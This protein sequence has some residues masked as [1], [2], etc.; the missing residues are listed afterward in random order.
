MVLCLS[1]IFENSMIFWLY[2]RLSTRC[3][4]KPANSLLYS[5]AGADFIKG[6]LLVPSH[7]VE[8]VNN[9]ARFTPFINCFS[10]YLSLFHITALAADRFWAV[11][12]PL[13][14]LVHHD[15]RAPSVELLSIWIIPLVL[16][17]I[18]LFGSSSP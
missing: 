1:I 8:R 17:I 5:Q 9:T 13:R 18:P 2:G 12:R 7:I 4:E 15:R 3:R 11:L 16:A 10:F 6:L 14:H